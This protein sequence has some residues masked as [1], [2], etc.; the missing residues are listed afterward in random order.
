MTVMMIRVKRRRASIVDDLL[1]LGFKQVTPISFCHGVVM[2]M[3][4]D[5]FGTKDSTDLIISSTDDADGIIR[6]L[7][8]DGLYI[9][10]H[11]ADNTAS[12]RFILMEHR[13]CGLLR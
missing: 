1:Q 6:L 7:K 13:K 9:S 4:H 10:H 11:L 5:N 2:V 12:D 8:D 3:A